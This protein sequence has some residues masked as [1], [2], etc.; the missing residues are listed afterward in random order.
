[1]RKLLLVAA[2]IIPFLAKAQTQTPAPYNYK[3]EDRYLYYSDVVKLDSSY[4]TSLL[5]TNAKLF[6]K[7]LALINTKVTGDDQAAGLLTA[8]IEEPATFKTQTGLSDDSMTMK[9]SIKLEIKKGRYRYTIDNIIIITTE[10]GGKKTSSTLYDLDKDR[11]GGVLRLGRAKRILK[12]MDALFMR[13][14]DALNNTMKKKS[15]DF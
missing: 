12:A 10:K 7:K 9:Y 3:V 15:D 1:M 2:F 8:D 11:D 5:Y 6:L 4:T 13:K 14:I